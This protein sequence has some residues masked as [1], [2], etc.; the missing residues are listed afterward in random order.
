MGTAQAPYE[1]N[2]AYVLL[3]PHS[4]RRQPGMTPM[5]GPS[6]QASSDIAQ[7][8]AALGSFLESLG[9]DPGQ[10]DLAPVDA[11]L[12]H[13][14]ARLGI[15]HERLEFLGDAVLRLA[16]AEFLEREH[17]TLTVG[18][19]SA[20]RAQMVSDRWLAELA[21]RCGLD[22]V[23]RIGPMASG[24]RAG[25]AT[26]SAECCEALIGAVYRCWGGAS[27]G[28]AAV[29]TWL[30]RPWRLEVASL[31]ADPHRHNWKSALQELTQGKGWG[32]PVYRCEQHASAHA[33]PRR[34]RCWV[35]V[36]GKERGDGWGG[37]RREAEQSAARQA[38]EALAPKPLPGS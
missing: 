11:A 15:N 14:S 21:D 32:L 10:R 1:Q 24:D 23:L 6:H 8:R 29:H 17:P 31:L 4:S 19:A 27:G 36:A 18:R 7:R 34:F 5:T 38:L 35:S 25:R 12:S 3:S 26:V 13:T 33:D 22:A 16:A 2:P 28:L 20:L 9:L 30:D 37:S